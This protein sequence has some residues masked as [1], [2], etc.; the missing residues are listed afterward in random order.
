MHP[1]RDQIHELV[2]RCSTFQ[3]SRVPDGYGYPNSLALCIVDSVQSTGVRYPSVEAVVRR[4]RDY[5]GKQGGDANRDGANELVA[6][7]S[8]L[9][10]PGEWTKVI[11]N[12]NKT[13]T[14]QGAPLKAVAIQSAAEAMVKQGVLTGEALRDVATNP[15]RLASVRDAWLAVPGQKSG[16]TWRYVLM[17]VGVPGVKPDRMIIR[18]VADTL[19]LNR[20]KVATTFA[21]DA[22][23]ETA[24]ALDMSPT[25]LDHAIWEWQRKQRSGAKRSNRP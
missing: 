11:G 5:R 13:S 18:F 22:I 14:R 15:E 16:I 19:G 20:R 4:Y 21:A 7:F 12:Q 2:E 17:L 23:T 1:S 3:G 6:T 25:D 9:N 8:E 10:D 24:N